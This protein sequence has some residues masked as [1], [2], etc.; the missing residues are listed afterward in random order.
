MQITFFFAD[1]HLSPTCHGQAIKIKT[2]RRCHLTAYGNQ[3]GQTL[4][5]HKRMVL[6]GVLLFRW[7]T[8]SVSSTFFEN[9]LTPFGPNPTGCIS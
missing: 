7:D 8:L 3:Q 4:Q 1:C 9:G 6:V 2:K 5:K